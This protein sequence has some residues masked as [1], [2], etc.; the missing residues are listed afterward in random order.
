MSEERKAALKELSHPDILQRVLA[1]VWLIWDMP[2]L[3]V[4]NKTFKGLVYESLIN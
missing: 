4:L 3:D 2:E 1:T